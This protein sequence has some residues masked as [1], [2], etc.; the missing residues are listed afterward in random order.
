MIKRVE[1]QHKIKYFGKEYSVILHNDSDFTTAFKTLQYPCGITSNTENALIPSDPDI[2][3]EI[4][5]E[6]GHRTVH[7][8]SDENGSNEKR[9][10]FI[11]G[12]FNKYNTNRLFLFLIVNNNATMHD[13]VNI[14][15]GF[16]K[17]SEDCYM[18]VILDSKTTK[19]KVRIVVGV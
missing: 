15:D 13:I 5:I 14:I 10:E 8:Y 3:N 12:I 4:F 16:C 9:R 7:F 2:Y 11:E 17:D 18:S 6:N 19:E 1:L